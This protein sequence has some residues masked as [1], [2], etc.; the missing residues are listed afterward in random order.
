VPHLAFPIR[1]ECG[2]YVTDQQDSNTE[3]T[4]CVRNICSFQKGVRIERPDFGILDPTLTVLPIDV[5]G[6]AQSIATWE[7]RANVEIETI[8]DMEGEETIN[9]RVAVPFN[10]DTST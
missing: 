6:I 2:I 3:V 8:A 7:P 5:N 9:I 10:E 1:V 4:T